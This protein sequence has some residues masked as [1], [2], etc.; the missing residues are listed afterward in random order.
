MVVLHCNGRTYGNAYLIT[1][2]VGPLSAHTHT[3][4]IDPPQV[5]HTLVMEKDRRV[6]R[7]MIS[8]FSHLLQPS[9]YFVFRQMIFFYFSRVRRRVLSDECVFHKHNMHVYFCIIL[10][11]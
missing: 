6:P 5:T 9:E 10:K 11:L 4:S 3:C 1:F 2:K 7:Y 8:Y